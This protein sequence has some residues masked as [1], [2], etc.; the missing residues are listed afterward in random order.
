[1]PRIVDP[2]CQL[3][4]HSGAS[5]PSEAWRRCGLLETVSSGE[6]TARSSLD[7]FCLRR[8]LLLRCCCLCSALAGYRRLSAAERLTWCP[9]GP[10][11]ACR[12]SRGQGRARA[13][14]HDRRRRSMRTSAAA[15]N[16]GSV[17]PE[18]LTQRVLAQQ[19]LMAASGASSVY[20]SGMSSLSLSPGKD[21]AHDPLQVRTSRLKR[22][23]AAC[24]LACR[25][26]LVHANEHALVSTHVCRLACMRACMVHASVYANKASIPCLSSM[27]VL[28]SKVTYEGQQ[29][30]QAVVCAH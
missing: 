5:G 18:R 30:D 17:S 15:G 8:L 12:R 23:R 24:M 28:R 27:H 9:G 3:L 21:R 22:T 4:L 19:R 25:R 20:A 14:D 7:G 2:A 26:T 13:R 29:Q 6:C 10:L 1:M 16:K 11:V